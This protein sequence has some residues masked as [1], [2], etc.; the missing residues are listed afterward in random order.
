[1]ILRGAGDI[2]HPSV[3]PTKAR[4]LLYRSYIGAAYGHLG[5]ENR[6]LVPVCI[7]DFIREI[8]PDPTG[9]YMGHMAAQ[10]TG[11]E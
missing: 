5:R 2:I 1:M 4:R 7:R 10:D 6:V 9:N 8:F 3:P 11:D